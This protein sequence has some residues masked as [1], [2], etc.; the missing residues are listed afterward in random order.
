[1]NRPAVEDDPTFV[2]ALRAGEPWARRRLYLTYGPHVA[3]ILRRILGHDSE[4][5]DI[6][7]D[8]FVEAYTS[9]SDLRDPS[10]VKAWLSRIAEFTARAKIRRRQV[11]KLVRF[12][13]PR[14]LPEIQAPVAGGSARDALGR[15]HVVLGQ[16]AVEERLIFVLRFIEGLDLREIATTCGCSL[17][18]VKRRLASAQKTFVSAAHDEP[19]MTRWL[20][21]GRWAGLVRAARGGGANDTAPVSEVLNALFPES[22]DV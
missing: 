10:A 17:A 4:L 19:A 16:L 21:S 22:A 13:D 5:Y 9:A 8:V 12:W 2:P 1:M 15:V 20:Q 6:L 18:T 3:S 7:Q 14:Q 11:R